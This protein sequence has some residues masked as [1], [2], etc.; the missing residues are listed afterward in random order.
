MSWL[1]QNSSSTINLEGEALS[2]VG[3]MILDD[4]YHQ[5]VKKKIK[6]NFISLW[7][8]VMVTRKGYDELHTWRCDNRW[9]TRTHGYGKEVNNCKHRLNIYADMVHEKG[10][11]RKSSGVLNIKYGC[12]IRKILYQ[13]FQVIHRDNH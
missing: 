5:V 10:K 13:I 9:K 2:M 6:E 11:Y 4:P 1:Q 12:R 8:M 3:M 7:S